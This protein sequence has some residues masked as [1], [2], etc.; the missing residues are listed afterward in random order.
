MLTASN[1]VTGN[2]SSKYLRYLPSIFQDDEF[3]GQFLRI[4]EDITTPLENTISNNNLYF[5]P[6]LTPLPF[7]EWISDWMD[8]SISKNWP[9]DK[10]R[11]LI[12]SAVELYRWR[13]T[14]RGLS[15]F[16]RIYTGKNPVITEYIP[17][18][19]LSEE[20]RLGPDTRLGS[21]SSGCQFSISLDSGN[22]PGIDEGTIRRI[23]DS[24]RPALVIYSLQ[25]TGGK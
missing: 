8:L 21:S 14:K 9:E 22:E 11:E 3:M 20:T 4:F 5:D 19:K 1:P 10:R 24:Q 15:E 17:G 12:K 25:I 18:M 6:D 2:S 7:L 13:G 16:L 23:I